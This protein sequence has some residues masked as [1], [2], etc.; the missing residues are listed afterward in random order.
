MSTKWLACLA[1]VL[2]GCPSADVDEGEGVGGPL[3]EFDPASRII[4]FPN[5]LLID[6]TTGK[7]NL[8]QQCNESPATTATRTG[9]LNQLD[10]F[11]TY[12]PAINVTFT[13]AIDV[14]SLTDRVLLFKRATGTTPVDPASAVAIPL[15]AVPNQTT[16]F[17]NQTDINACTDPVTVEQVTFVPALPLEGSSVYTVGLLQGIK[18]ASGGDF[19]PSFTWAL[20]RQPEPVVVIDEAGTVTVN[21]TPLDPRKE[22]DLASLQGIDLL[23]KAHQGALTFLDGTGNPRDTILLAWDF[24][25][26]TTTVPLD[27]SVTGS[28][29]SAHP[30]ALPLLG[31]SNAQTTGSAA[32]VNRLGPFAACDGGDNNTQCFLKIVIG[33]GN[34]LVGNAT[35]AQIGC[36]AIGDVL[37]SLMLSKQYQAD[38]DN[39]TYTG[40]GALPIPGQWSDPLNP[41]VVHNTD[42]ANPLLNDPQT[43]IQ[44]LVFIPVTAA[45]ANGYP[46]AIFQHGLGQSKTNA[47]AIAGAM[48]AQGFATVAIDAQS[49][50]SRAV[51]ISDDPNATPTSC[52]NP[53]SPGLFP[54]ADGGPSPSAAPHCYAPFLSP[55]LG[56]TRD[57]IR[58]T[59]LDHQQL[60][61]SLKACGTTACGALEV[62]G[63][64]IV[65]IGQSLG[66]I[67]G[68]MTTATADI[69]AAV[70]NVPGAGWAD[71]LEN[72]QTLA[73]KCSLVDGLIGAGILQGDPFDPVAGTGL[74][75]GD[76]WKLQPGYRQFSVIG[77]W[78]LDSADPANFNT[79][80]AAKRFLIQRVDGDL[81][82]PNIA[83]DREGALV[84]LTAADAKCAVPTGAGPT[85]TASPAITTDAM[86]NKFVN[87]PTIDVGTASCPVGN[88]YDHGS[89]L[90]PAANQ[91]G[92]PCNP[93]TG[94]N[95][96]AAF[97]TAQMQTDAITFLVINRN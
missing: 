67:L 14:A 71:I 80:L 59:I 51:R 2:G 44:A 47:F 3:V 49:H 56:A 13:E 38:V 81:V 42:N 23:W 63:T 37:G 96:D 33:Q 72:T 61:T 22:D 78:V 55:N 35:C 84:G 70:L 94:A 8:P 48:A 69:K 10:G 26:Q 79:K 54:R 28:L 6:P 66:G 19:G 88:T 4:P 97:S 46:T 17:L 74:C 73:I 77:R 87:Y 83:T 91:S 32:V 92:N 85:F 24:K 89:L 25:T 36:A 15:V 27:P 34:Y 18:T 11:G 60:V 82:V 62:D 90:R 1:V 40:T 57:G 95:C 68:S 53:A 21:R 50:D 75:V 12:Q 41:T 7:V 29:A 65:Y 31:N 58:Q 76:E 45:P 20:V 39:T 93:G 43:Q 5:N 52:A 86:S 16:R 30:T 64:K 9:V